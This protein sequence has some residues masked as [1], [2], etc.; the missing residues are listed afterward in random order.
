MALCSRAG[1]QPSSDDD[2]IEAMRRA[3][4]SY[5]DERNAWRSDA[6]ERSAMVEALEEIND[7][8]DRE[9]WRVAESLC[10]AAIGNWPDWSGARETASA[11][12][13]YLEAYAGA[14]SARRRPPPPDASTLHVA[15]DE[16]ALPSA[17]AARLHHRASADILGL[18]FGFLMEADALA[19]H[20]NGQDLSLEEEVALAPWRQRFEDAGVDWTRD[21]LETLVLVRQVSSAWRD[22]APYSSLKRI[23]VRTDW[24][25]PADFGQ[26]FC[27]VERLT[28]TSKR[29]VL[30][31]GLM[32]LNTD[33]APQAPIASMLRL[34]SLTLDTTDIQ[35]MPAW[36]RSLPL[37]ELQV[38]TKDETNGYEWDRDEDAL[39]RTLKIFRLGDFSE[40][41]TLQCLRQ[42]TQL[43]EV[44]LGTTHCPSW[45]GQLLPNLKHVHGCLAP[46]HSYADA[47]QGVGLETFALRVPWEHEDLNPSHDEY[48]FADPLA[49]LLSSASTTLQSLDLEGHRLGPSLDSFPRGLR[50]CRLLRRLDLVKCEIAVLPDW[51]GE[52]PLVVL[53]L[54]ANDELENLPLSMHSQ[55]T[56]RLIKL[57]HTCLSGPYAPIIDPP[58]DEDSL[59]G[60]VCLLTQEGT[61]P[62]EEVSSE[63][64]S[65]RRAALMA[66]SRALPDLRLELHHAMSGRRYV[67]WCAGDKGDAGGD[68]RYAGQT[69]DPLD[70]HWAME[71]ASDSD[72]DSDAESEHEMD[73]GPLL[74]AAFEPLEQEFHVNRDHLADDVKQSLLDLDDETAAGC[75]QALFD[76][77]QQQALGTSPIDWLRQRI[78]EVN[79]PE[80]PAPAPA[81]GAR[82]YCSV[83]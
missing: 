62:L 81:A 50:D 25:L 30:D 11:L 75:V 66:I 83:A 49:R 48:E 1:W 70:P 53:D 78:A 76:T 38:T 45:L 18:V 26:R 29:A 69:I 59:D 52:L 20:I 82:S 64:L 40:Q 24:D 28:V 79:T 73:C 23:V 10:Q 22:A 9:E 31:E 65:R 47:L 17:R 68:P 46:I 44:H 67:C 8:L 33:N 5:E 36:L 58:E 4:G 27:G 2:S 56:L 63:E 12:K 39:P 74:A 34:R 3:S 19:Y 55:R 37:E 72:S 42:L 57:R 13:T 41:A 61:L 43:E 60:K 35:R 21:R 71:L 6:R 16:A 14:K 7:A 51:I 32:L 54:T 80:T 77:L 15:V